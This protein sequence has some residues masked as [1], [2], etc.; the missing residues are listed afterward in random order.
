MANIETGLSIN[1]KKHFISKFIPSL[2][3]LAFAIFAMFFISADEGS[4]QTIN[5]Y[6]GVWSSITSINEVSTQPIPQ[7]LIKYTY[8][9]TEYK[10]QD[11][12]E[13]KDT[14]KVGDQVRIYVNPD[15]PTDFIWGEKALASAKTVEYCIIICG[16]GFALLYADYQLLKSTK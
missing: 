3:F 12:K 13:Y 6:E 11:L 8:K 5:G 16:I 9:S 2:F 7:V 1:N 15:K 4:V 10:D 14:M